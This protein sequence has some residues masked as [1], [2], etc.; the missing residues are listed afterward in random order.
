MADEDDDAAVLSDVEEADDPAPLLLPPPSFTTASSSSSTSSSAA[1]DQQQQQQQQQRIRDLLA[2][3]EAERRARRAAED[4]RADSESRLHRLKAFAQDVIKKRDDALRSADDAAKKLDD[5]AAKLAEASARGDALESEI[6]TASQMLASGL[7]KISGKISAFRAFPPD[8]LPKSHK[9]AAGLPALA[10]GVVK[11]TN[12]IV[13]ELL[14]QVDAAAKSRDQAREQ[15]DQRNYEI[16][17][18]VSQLEATIAG[19]RGENEKLTRSLADRDAKIS[20]MAG[21]IAELRQLGE[22]CDGKLKSLEAKSALQRTV[23]VDHLYYISKVYEQ[24]NDI[25]G[26]VDSNEPESRDPPDL[27][28]VRKEI[29]T[30][31]DLKTSSEGM[32]SVYELSKAAAEKVRERIEAMNGEAVSLN[33]KVVSLLEEKQHISTLLRGS[34]SSDPNKVLHVADD[35][36][37]KEDEV[38][39]LAGALENTVKESQLKIIEL[40][41]L[42][43]AL[44]AESSA[45]KARLDAQAKEISQQ[46]QRIKELEEKE[47]V[48]NENVEGLMTDIAAAEEEITRWKVAAEQEAAAGGA[49]EQEL[50]T[51]ISALR[52]ELE[53]TRQAM[54]ELENKLKFKEETA[55]A[56]MAARDAAEKSLRL[57]DLRAARLR[58]RLEELT[59]QLEEYDSRGE[60]T[61]RNSHRYICWPWQWLGLNSVRYQQADIQENSNEMELSEPLI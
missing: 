19:L 10:F 27:L 53:D 29:E 46:K 41:H 15:A 18:E 57:A 32:I 39:T 55:A 44:R 40:Q 42:V 48:A 1:S 14:R 5:A 11:R 58:E 49:V 21:E 47:R 34:L 36:G 50:Q 45:F 52:K 38:Y 2:E 56:A 37:F 33:E 9:Y 17:I 8:G 23:L 28:F 12:E 13:E 16:A 24:I 20:D 54:V 31:D 7:D 60:T 35:E 22:D 6:S 3:L 61:N 51:Q 59:R 4:G 25:V 30:S 43:E 26:I